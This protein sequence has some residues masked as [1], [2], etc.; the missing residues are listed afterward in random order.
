MQ[1][2][3][4]WSGLQVRM[5][6]SYVIVTIV[7]VLV[8]ELAL[9]GFVALYILKGGNGLVS[10]LHLTAQQYASVVS[11]KVKDSTLDT[12]PVITL[13][14]RGATITPGESITSDKVV[15]I[16][17]INGNQVEPQAFTFALLIA[18]DKHIFASSYPKR[19]PAKTHIEQLLPN[20]VAMI[21]EALRG[22]SGSDTDI[23]LMRNSVAYAVQ[24]VWNSQHACKNIS[25]SR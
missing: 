12:H 3:R 7:A 6:I 8:L 21:D 20:K 14:E 19:Y 11:A 2:L 15:V 22:T 5:T 25:K 17:Y 23:S 10:K 1:K 24:P 4:R 13:G 18:P 16:P 9:F